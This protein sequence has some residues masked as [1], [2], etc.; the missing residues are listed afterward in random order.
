MGFLYLEHSGRPHEGMIP[1]SGRY[2]W[3]SGEDG[4]QGVGVF[5]NTIRELEKSGATEKQIAEL[6][7][8]TTTELRSRKS[9]D[10]DALRQARIRQAI[11]LRDEKGYSYAKIGEIIGGKDGP[12]GDTTV[13]GWLESS[14]KERAEVIDN[15]AEALKEAVAEKKYVDVGPGVASYM[16]VSDTKLAS[17]MKK[18]EAEGYHKLNIDVEQAGT[19]FKTRTAV[20]CKD[21]VTTRELQQNLDKIQPP[22]GIKFEDNGKTRWV[23]Q[24]PVSVDRSRVDIKYAEDGGT[25]MDGVILIRPGVEDLNLGNSH[26]AQVRI[27]VGDNLYLK[28]MA[29][30]SDDI[31]KGK[32]IVFNTNKSKGMPDDEVLKKVKED[33]FLKEN[34]FGASI[35]DQNKWVD[36]NGV[37]HQGAINIVNEEGDWGEWSKTLSS[38]FLSKQP[39]SL[40]KKQLNKTYDEKLQEYNEIMKLTNPDVRRE[41]L[42]SFADDCDASA[43]HLKATGMPR[44]ASHVILPV[45]DMPED[46]IYAPQYNDGETVVLIRYPHGGRFEIP[47]LTVD[48][49]TA[50]VESAKKYIGDSID[51][52]GIHPK[53]AERLS[54]ADFDGDTVLVIPN[55]EGA[56]KTKSPLAKLKDFN[57]SE[58]YKAYE[59]MPKVGEDGYHKQY[60]MGTV[61][62]LITDMTIKGANDDEIARAVRHSMVVIDA[63]KHQLD[64]KGSYAKEGILEL[65]QKYQGEIDP[66][67]GRLHMGAATLISRAR[68]RADVP[69]RKAYFTVDPNTGEKIFT[70]TGRKYT[71]GKKVLDPDTGEMTWV[72]GKEKMATTKMKRLEVYNADELSSGTAMETVYADYSNK[73]KALANQARK[74][75][76]ETPNQKYDPSAAKTYAQE[77]ASLNA[78]LNLALKNAPLER[79]AQRY[80]ASAIR[81]LKKDNPNMDKEE[82]KKIKSQTLNKARAR[83]GANKARIKV[84]P[85]EWEAIQAGAITHT[86][87]T[88]ILKNTDLD[89]IRQYATPKTTVS[90]SSAQVAQIKS[91]L[92]N[93]NVTIADIASKFGVSASTIYSLARS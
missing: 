86:T 58:A 9:I 89:I 69:E 42:D 90:I 50:A 76:L 72:P 67:T 18:L 61:S 85:K 37:E 53:V 11:Y 68:N 57:P 47:T 62:N 75:S 82:L 38:Q 65:K 66:V 87:L 27:L 8:M 2:P 44:Q 78:Q 60:Q 92:S 32:D 28:G 5:Y 34:P 31:P 52:V 84:T 10:K 26:Y 16:G 54:G 45:P 56:I 93:P 40:A 19:T 13:R 1:H 29:M 15:V 73:M 59:G 35:V 24:Y 91:M 41:L 21:D 55:N 6:M 17:A 49:K 33:R 71:P 80:T 7:G 22:N 70:E 83:V 77:V 20:F 43:V 81:G 64:W 14:Q 79:L 74:S 3:G 23:M 39:V 30:Y 4:F 12:I 63:E 36:K 46:K 51:A 25:N 88:R 48:N